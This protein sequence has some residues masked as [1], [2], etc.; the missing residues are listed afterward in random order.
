MYKI[1]PLAEH[2]PSLPPSPAT[3][4]PVM[5]NLDSFFNRKLQATALNCALKF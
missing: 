1:S 5:R 3:P 4:N 2:A